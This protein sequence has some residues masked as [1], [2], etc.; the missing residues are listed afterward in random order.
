[1][2]NNRSFSSAS[3]PNHRWKTTEYFSRKNV[4]QSVIRISDE[5]RKCKQ[6]VP[7]IINRTIPEVKVKEVYADDFVRLCGWVLT[8]GYFS[9]S[10]KT[11]VGVCQS[12]PKTKKVIQQLMDRL[13]VTT[14]A[15]STMRYWY[16]GGDLGRDVR[17]L[18]PRRLLSYRFISS[19]SRRQADIL[20]DT[21]VLGDGSS[22]GGKT[23][24]CCGNCRNASMA[25]AREKANAF[26]ALCAWAGHATSSKSMKQK[27]PAVLKSGQVIT[28]NNT[29][30]LVTILRRVNAQIL[31]KHEK[32]KKGNGVWCPT[33]DDDAAWIAR[34]EGHTY[35]TKNSPVQSTAHTYMLIAMALLDLRPRTYHLLMKCIMEV[36]D[37][38]YF[39]V[40]LRHLVEAHAQL[41]R[42]FETD[43]VDYA[44]RAFNLR[45]RVPLLVDAEAGFCMSS[46]IGYEGEDLETFLKAWRIKQAEMDEKSWEDLMPTLDA[47]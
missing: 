10:N 45:L 16:V 14:G 47:D 30:Y 1:V 3:T 38:L 20:I 39:K 7:F 40:R 17:D 9:G 8:D 27:K 36:H 43:V 35:I 18:F 46:L 44:Q 24:L 11:G 19:L 37:A 29:Y 33:F 25:T 26:Q 12:K 28:A 22:I 15:D 31:R 2:W 42:L 41:T 4:P 13:G 6:T 21:M 23:T 34:R 5:L 32:I